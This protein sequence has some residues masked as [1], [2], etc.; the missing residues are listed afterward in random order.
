MN[1]TAQQIAER[2]GGEVIGDPQ[3]KVSAPARIEQGRPGTI[4]FF[5]NPKYEHYIYTTKASILLVNK[6]FEPRQEIPA[7]LIKVDNA[8]ESVALLLDFF[9]S[10]KKSRPRSNRFLYAVHFHRK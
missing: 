1:I 5:V 6:S 8:Y 4:C 3:V 2:L 7:T 9:N 10:L